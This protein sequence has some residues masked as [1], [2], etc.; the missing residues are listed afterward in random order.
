MK[1]WDIDADVV[2][3]GSGGAGLTA[4]I[5]AHDHGARVVVLER[6]DKVGGT[7]AVSGGALWIPMNHQMAEAGTPD[8]REEA[9]A[10]C[11][12][13]ADGRAPDELVETFVDTG[14]RMVRYLEDRTPVKLHALML[15]D[16]QPGLEG[17]RPGGRTIEPEF[18]SKRE[19]GEWGSRLR[20]SPIYLLP[21]TLQ[22]LLFEYQ[23]H[24]RPQNLPA[25]LIV[26]RMER[27]MVG[28]GSALIA[29]LLKACLSRGIS[30]LLETRARELVVEDGRVA[31]LR[32]ERDGKE[33]FAKAV[34]GVVLA[35]GGFE[36]SDQ[37]QAQFL[38]GPVAHPNS[39]PFNEGDALVM[40]AEVGAA[41]GNMS[42]A[43][44]SPAAAV[45][46]EE[47]EGRQ[48]S[49][50][51]VP[52][53][54]C[55]HTILVNRRGARFVNEGASYNELGKVFNDFDPSVDEYRNQPCWAVFDRQYRRRYPVLTV[56]PGDPDPEWL[57]R[58]DTLDG[59]AARVGI[60]PD[61]LLATIARWN[62]F[63]PTGKDP[64]FERHRYPVDF[65]APHPS[66][67]SIEKAPFY[68][69]PVHKGMLGTKGGPRTNTRGQVLDVR[70][71]VVQGLYAAG[72]AMAGVSGPGYGGGGGTI[73][74]AMTW[75][76]ICGIDAA[77]G[78]KTRRA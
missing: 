31:G 4:A 1:R 58:D 77:S 21:L 20:L 66:M 56:L 60:D 30:V 68:A 22:E 29:R 74:L 39:P 6:S 38:P 76:Y 19:L 11:K 52:E 55:P 63:V 59:L 71:A 40:A 26:G 5:L 28:C 53:R 47:Y 54:V 65:D 8:S 57:A 36:W 72:N 45:P 49:R 13:L 32:A 9:L 7:T 62:A 23:A 67:G 33:Y 43:W 24:I 15:P 12:R 10:Y 70:G 78:S 3:V 14:H 18:F 75:G 41:L 2:V 46:G 73:G 48:L 42:E 25:D 16:Y 17:A 44:G 37:M 27:D 64:D 50:L 61:G 35:S 51:V 34:G 69:L